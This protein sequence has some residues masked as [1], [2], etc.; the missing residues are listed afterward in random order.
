MPLNLKILKCIKKINKIKKLKKKGRYVYCKT[1]IN[2]FKYVST[3][4]RKYWSYCYII[5]LTLVKDCELII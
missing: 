5:N 1:L 3:F 4:I 2:N